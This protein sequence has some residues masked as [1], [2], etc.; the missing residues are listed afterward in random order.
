MRTVYSQVCSH[1]RLAFVSFLDKLIL[2][3]RLLKAAQELAGE[4]YLRVQR[5]EIEQQALQG[6][7]KLLEAQL[8]SLEMS[9]RGRLGGRPRKDQNGNGGLS[10]PLPVGAQLFPPEER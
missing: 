7:I 6:R 5:L 3:R 8:S 2:P 4:A 1:A 10:T 9:V